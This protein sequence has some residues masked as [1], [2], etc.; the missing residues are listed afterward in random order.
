MLADFLIIWNVVKAEFSQ[1][2]VFNHAL[3]HV[4]GGTYNVV[5]HSAGLNDRIHLLVGL[6]HI[7]DNLY[8]GFILKLGDD[9]LV[10]V[11]APVVYV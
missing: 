7:V 4:V 9:I 11:L 2:I 6:K 1:K 5:F 8:A 10:N 3:N